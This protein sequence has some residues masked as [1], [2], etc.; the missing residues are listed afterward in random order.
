MKEHQMILLD[1]DLRNVYARLSK[2]SCIHGK[3][4]LRTCADC[5]RMEVQ[6][7]LNAGVAQLGR[8]VD[9]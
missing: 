6:M 2:S 8:A 3:S 5:E 4:K 7:R 9:P 1:A